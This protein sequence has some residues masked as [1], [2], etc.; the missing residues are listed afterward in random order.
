MKYAFAAL[1]ALSLFA[2]PG[3]AFAETTQCHNITSLPATLSSQ[4]VYCLKQHLST[5]QA[6][7]SAIEIK[8]NN[9]TIDCN[10]Y[11]IGG[12][13]A[14]P[15]TGAIGIHAFN[16]SNITI[17][18]CKLRG[19]NVGIMLGHN[20]VEGA[21]PP[22]GHMV[23]HNRIDNSMRA[24]I[25][26]G[27][28]GSMV[29]D[30][31][32]ADTGGNPVGE[33]AIGIEA[34]FGVD[35]MDNTVDGVFDDSDAPKQVFGILNW[36]GRG[37]VISGN[38]IRGLSTGSVTNGIMLTYDSERVSIRDNAIANGAAASGVGIR[39]I[40]ANDIATG[41]HVGGFDIGVSDCLPLEGSGN[42]VVP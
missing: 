11:K 2:C 15:A 4:G 17:R 29:R 26:I 12:L 5:S 33:N 38:R 1:S 10:G 7:G 39:C 22:S 20:A 24:G 3:A 31:V 40:G 37:N 21:T 27:A 18:N 23:E 42:I 30:N 14:G 36:T 41:N 9:I 19:F 6:T 28:D 16:Q 25:V 35:I 13:A 8:T 32:I 34:F